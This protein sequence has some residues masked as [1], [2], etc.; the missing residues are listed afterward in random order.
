MTSF[1]AGNLNKWCSVFG[2]DNTH[3]KK[4]NGC[5]LIDDTPKSHTG[6]GTSENDDYNDD[7]TQY[8][9]HKEWLKLFAGNTLKSKYQDGHFAYAVIPGSGSGLDAEPPVLYVIDIENP[10]EF[11]NLLEP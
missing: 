3:A 7:P 5:N 10:S 2:I 1:A 11:N 4:P 6:N 9:G 8:L